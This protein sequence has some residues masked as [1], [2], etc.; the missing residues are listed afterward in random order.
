MR[1]G[2]QWLFVSFAGVIHPV[3]VSGATL[4]FGEPWP[5][6]DDADRA[7]NWRVGGLQHLAVHDKTGRLYVLMHQGGPDTHKDP[8]SE[9]WVYDIAERRRL[10]RIPVANPLVS[11]IALTSALDPA[12]WSRWA[13]EKTLPNPGIERILVTQD[14]QPVLVAGTSLPPA[15]MIHD[16]ITGAPLREVSEPGLAGTLLFAP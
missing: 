3:D 9:V 4:A 15:I 10:Q 16:A 14:D 13:L 7:A 12:S 8:G 11:F 5:L 1:R 2:D 6:L